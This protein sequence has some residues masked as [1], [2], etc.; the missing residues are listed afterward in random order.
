MRRPRKF[1]FH[2]NVGEYALT[3]HII[4][5]SMEE[6]LR[7]NYKAS[8]ITNN[9]NH[10]FSRC[11]IPKAFLHLYNLVVYV[12]NLTN[13][14]NSK[15]KLGQ[16][17]TSINEEKLD[18]YLLFSC[19]DLSLANC[20]ETIQLFRTMIWWDSDPRPWNE[21]R[22]YWSPEHFIYSSFHTNPNRLQDIVPWSNQIK[23]S[24]KE[25]SKNHSSIKYSD[26]SD[27]FQFHVHLRW[28]MVF[29]GCN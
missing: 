29:R 22:Y 25:M 18:F 14:P 16:R 28:F 26:K 4:F 2:T 27:L 15:L 6:T 5:I 9:Q 1:K 7:G 3:Q 12:F 20:H 11:V 24:N 13:L 17:S 8:I 19:W 21:H 23:R 10:G